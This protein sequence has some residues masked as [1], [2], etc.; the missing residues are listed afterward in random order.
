LFGMSTPKLVLCELVDTKLAGVESYSPFCLKAHRALK[1]AGL[2]YERR[3]GSRPASFRR[4]NPTAQVPVLLVDD[5]A[6]ADSTEILR[7]IVALRPSAIA[8]GAEAWLW[9][10]LADS[11]L[12]GFVVAARWADERNWPLTRATYFAKMPSLVRAI[13]SSRLRKRVIGT[14]IGRDV[15]RAGADRCWARFET[16]IDQLDA[17][18]PERGWWCGGALSV[19]DIA[20]FAQLHSL[21]TPLTA[22]QATSLARRKRLSAWLDRVHEETKCAAP[23]DSSAS[24]SYSAAAS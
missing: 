1:A 7:R 11:A 13:V 16:L 9:E 10:E 15:W 17:R 20:L 4:H 24:F 22:P 19:A 18:A 12:Y 2:P 3:H 5:T 6:V 14:L 21:R 23:I 8:A